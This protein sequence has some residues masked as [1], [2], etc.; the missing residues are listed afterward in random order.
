MVQK[1]RGSSTGGASMT[2]MA[3]TGVPTP[4]PF[5]R[6]LRIYLVD[7]GDDL[8]GGDVSLRSAVLTEHDAFID[9][10]SLIE[11][12]ADIVETLTRARAV[13][14]S[15]PKQVRV[16]STLL[17]WARGLQ[18]SGV[19]ANLRP[20]SSPPAQR[21]ANH[22]VPQPAALRPQR[23]P[24]RRRSLM[25]TLVAA[26]AVC[27]AS[28]TGL[29]GYALD[30]VETMVDTANTGLSYTVSESPARRRAA[31]ATVAT[32]VKIPNIIIVEREEIFPTDIGSGGRRASRRDRRPTPRGAR[33]SR[34]ESRPRG[35]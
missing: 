2:S 31:S 26:A 30:S 11:D 23:R 16:R 28:V 7:C 10:R 27:C 24:A 18:T 25:G 13:S 3:S 29:V 15:G 34:G 21:P 33:M 17:D 8:P 1:R 22:H 9:V 35:G 5:V 12:G 32:A 4:L 6:C 20:H 19:T 14:R